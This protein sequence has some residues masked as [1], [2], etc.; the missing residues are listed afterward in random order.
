MHSKDANF[1]IDLNHLL[2]AI[3]ITYKYDFND[4]IR[5]SLK[6]RMSQALIKLKCENLALLEDK[7]VKDP[8]AF[9][10]L[11]Q[12]LT[13]SVTEMFRDPAYFKEIRDNVIPQLKTY[14]SL[15]I[16]I[17]GCSTGEE[18]YSLAILLKEEGLLERSH[19]YATDINAKSLKKADAGTF[20]LH[21]IENHSANY[22]CAGG[23]AELKDYFSIQ[24]GIAQIDDDLKKYITFT[25]HSL[26]TDNVFLETHFI[27]CRNVL[28]YFDK[29][30]QERVLGLFHESLCR[31][32]FLG[33]GQKESVGISK[34]YELFIPL[35]KTSHIFQ[36]N[37][38]FLLR[39]N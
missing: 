27:L 39:R 35:S 7:I 5:L 19:I 37:D 32:G 2:Q 30:L 1:D 28:I 21:E 29:N 16:W 17:A 36:K 6:R 9:S 25:D 8:D 26:A 13:V 23:K 3:Y 15:K 22:L 10:E 24:G 20:S 38:E 31:K 34:Y 12:Y 14:P 11:L 18:V 33:L 4:Y